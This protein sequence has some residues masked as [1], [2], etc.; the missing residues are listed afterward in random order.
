MT[1]HRSGHASFSKPT[2][3]LEQEVVTVD[4]GACPGEVLSDSS[5]PGHPSCDT[6]N[7]HRHGEQPRLLEQ[8]RAVRPLSEEHGLA[9]CSLTT[10]CRHSSF[11]HGTCPH[12]QVSL[13]QGTACRQ[14]LA[15]P[16]DRETT[17]LSPSPSSL[18]W[19]LQAKPPGALSPRCVQ[20][21]L[22]PA[23]W[24]CRT[25]WRRWA[26]WQASWCF[27]GSMQLSS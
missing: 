16:P 19:H 10:F 3:A 9:T 12:R 6:S 23:C 26:G 18:P 8:L 21:S 24:G 14:A 25:L 2:R 1:P 15:L 13:G 7:A 5:C 4:V 22:A 20:Q 17:Q 27:S 11:R